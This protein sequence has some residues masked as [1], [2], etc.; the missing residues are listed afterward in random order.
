MFVS[1]RSS[2]TH[3]NLGSYYDS[4]RNGK[5]NQ[6]LFQEMVEF[7]KEPKSRGIIR[8]QQRDPTSFLEFQSRVCGDTHKGGVIVER[9]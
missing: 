9:L 7:A 8:D 5:I 1:T 6:W 4:R 3:V 2:A